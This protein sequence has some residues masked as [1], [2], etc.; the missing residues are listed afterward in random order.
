[1]LFA[2]TRFAKPDGYGVLFTNGTG[3]GKTY[4]GLGIVKR[5]HMQG[6]RNGLIV[7]PSEKIA[8]DWM[9]AGK[10]LGL[11][12]TALADTSDAGKGIV[13]TTYA[14]LGA[15]DAVM[16]RDMDFVLA[17]EAQQLMQSADAATT[18]ALDAV[19]AL[20]LHPT[21]AIERYN[22][23]N[24]EDIAKLAAM[25]EQYEAWSKLRNRDDTMDVMRD[26]LAADM[27]KLEAQMNPLRDKLAKKRAE[28]QELV[29]DRQGA[30]RPRAVFLS[31]TPF[32]Y[33][34]NVQWA[35]GYLFEYPEVK[36]TGRYNQP[37]PYQAFMVQ[38]F[39]YSMR[40][41]KLNKPS[42][43]VDSDLMQRNF[44]TFLRKSGVLSSRMLDVDFDYERRF[45][46]IKEGI[47]QKI[48]EGMKWLRE[49]D[50][51]RYWKLYDQINAQFDSLTR[52]RLLEA[53]KARE[54]VPFIKAQHDLGRKVVVF[55]DFNT[56]GGINLFNVQELLA[57]VLAAE[58]KNTDPALATIKV[59]KRG[60][61]QTMGKVEEE[62]VP[63]SQLLRE[64]IE[65]RPDLQ[66]IDFR[67]YTSPLD[68]LRTA[69]PG[70]G[71]YNGMP[72]F[73]KSRLQAIDNFNDDAQPGANLLLVQKNANAGWS[74]HDTT[75][76]HQR[77]LINLG[78]PTEPTVSIQQEGR[79]YR[80]GQASDAIFHYFNTG[81]TWERIAFA[82]TISRRAGTA[83]NLAMGE[84]A[85]GLREAYIQ[86]FEDSDP[87]YK[88]SAAD[89]KGGKAKDR[90]LVKALTDWDRARALYFAKQ[91]RNSSNK[92]QEG[93]DFFATPE[94]V[95]LK[96]VEWA[97]IRH[98]E[99]LLEP[100]A[101]DGAIARWFPEKQE[102]TVVEPSLEL[103]SRLA[104]ATDAKLVATRFEDFNTVNK[105]DVIVMNPPFGLGG[106]TSTE[107]L[108]KAIKHLNDGGRIVALLPDGPAANKRLDALL[109]GSSDVPAKPVGTFKVNG[110]DV[111]IYEGDTVSGLIAGSPAEGLVTRAE[112]NI[113]FVKRPGA[114]TANG[115]PYQAIREVKPTG[116]RTR[117]VP[118]AP[119]VYEVARIS[120]PM[121]AFE[122]AGTDVK[123]HI[124]ILDKTLDP[125]KAAA[126]GQSTRDLSDVKTVKDLF[127]RLESM[128][129]PKRQKAAPAAPP[130][131]GQAPKPAPAARAEAVER[132]QASG[133]TPAEQGA[134]TFNLVGNKIETDAPM[135]T[136]E[137]KA[138]KKLQ[139][140]FVP[141]GAMAKV[142]DK[143]TWRAQGGGGQWF[144][145]M[146]HVVRPGASGAQ[147]VNEPGA[148][149]QVD[150]FG[151]PL[152]L[153][154]QA[155][156]AATKRAGAGRPAQPASAGDMDAAGAVPGDTPM[157][158]GEFL[159]NTLVG[160]ERTHQLSARK[161]ESSRDLAQAMRHLYRSA[162]ERF[163]ALVTDKS[164]KPLAIVGGFKGAISSASVQI[165]T[166]VGEAVRVPNAA[167]IWFAHNHPSGRADL[168]NADRRLYERLQGV[169]T[170]SGIE[171]QGLIAVSRNAYSFTNAFTNDDDVMPPA[172]EPMNV[173]GIERVLDD[174]RD[175]SQSPKADSPPAALQLG[176]QLWAK[177][178]NGV[179]LLDAQMRMAGWTPL[180][181]SVDKLR[182]TGGLN[183]LY[184]ALS[185]SNA[186]SAILVHDGV[187]DQKISNTGVST[188]QNVAAALQLA[189]VNV[190]DSLNV[191]SGMSQASIGRDIADGPVFSRAAGGSTPAF[192]KWFGDSKV[193]DAAGAP[194]VMYHG[195]AQDIT[196]FRPQQANAIFVT[197]DPEF[198]A[199][200]AASSE[201]KMLTKADEWGE[202]QSSQ[203]ILPVYV[204]AENPFD[205]E[206]PAHRKAVA[207]ALLAAKG[208]VRPDGEM[209]LAR[210]DG[211]PTLYTAPVIEA[212]MAR[213]DWNFIERADVQA[214]IRSQGHDGFYVEEGGRKNLGVYEPAQLKSAVGNRGAFDGSNPDLRA[215]RGAGR[216]G[217][218]MQQLQALRDRVRKAM[219]S[220]PEI[221]LHDSPSEAEIGLRL[222]IQ[223]AGAFNDVE[224]ALYQ[225]RIY[226][227]GR[228]LASL[229]RAEFVLAEHEVAHAG[230]RAVLGDNLARAMNTVAEMNPALRKLAEQ[231]V[232]TQGL[233][234]A[235]AMEEVLV[236]IPS[237]EL[238]KLK[239]WRGLVKMMADGLDR[240]G[241][242]RA[243]AVLR[244][245]L[246]GKT[247][248][249]D[250][251]EA[252]AG[253]LIRAARD[254][255][256]AKPNAQARGQMAAQRLEAT[257]GR[258]E[259][260]DK[261]ARGRGFK[262]AAAMLATKPEVHAKLQDLWS[263][264]NPGV[265][266]RED[267]PRWYSALTREVGKVGMNAA[268][269]KGWA[270]TIKGMVQKGQVKQDE[271]EWTGLGD[272]LALQEGKV[273]KE[274]V[275]EFLDGNGVQVQEVTLS[276]VQARA[277]PPGWEIVSDEDG[278]YAVLDEDGEVMGEGE[279]R[280]EALE[281]AQDEDA[282]PDSAGAP[283]YGQYTLPG[284]E[285]YREVLLTLPT[286]DAG[287]L[288]RANEL[289]RLAGVAGTPGAERVRLLQERDRLR[290]EAGN[291][292]QFK[293][294]H[295][296]QPNILAHIRVN[297]RT[298]ADGKRVLF[299]EEIQ[300]D[301][302][303]S[304]KKQRDSEAAIEART[305]AILS[306]LGG[307]IGR[308]DAE[309]WHFR[310]MGEKV[311]ANGA[312]SYDEAKA[313]QRAKAERMARERMG[314]GTTPAA[315]FVTKTEGWLNLALKRVM[316]MAVEGG[317]DRVAFVTGEQ[318]A[319]RYDLSKQVDQLVAYEDNTLVAR[320]GGRNVIERKFKDEAELAD[321]IGKE[322][323]R[324]LL[325]ARPDMNNQRVL[326]GQDLKV[327]G[328]GMK[329]FYD[330]IVPN[331][332]KGLL[333]KVGG[334]QVGA[335]D[336]KLTGMPWSEYEKYAVDHPYRK[337]NAPRVP[338][339]DITPAMR[340]KLAAGLPLFSRAPKPRMTRADTQTQ[341]FDFDAPA[342]E[343]FAL[344]A[345]TRQDVLAQ[346]QAR[347]DET[348]REAAQRRAAEEL[349]RK[350]AERKA[351]AARMDASAENFQ[352]G[353]S[354]E[355]A[356]SGQ[357]GLFS[358][359]PTVEERADTIIGQKAA[360]KQRLDK[361]LQTLTRLSGIE[362]V[363]GQVYDTGAYL[364]NRFTPGFVKAGVIS[365]YGLADAIKDRR[366][367]LAGRQRN[368]IRD[369]GKMVQML[370]TLT[371]EESRVA[372]E[373]LNGDN[374]STAEEMLQALPE[375]SVKVLEQVRELI[376]TMSQ[377][378]MRLKQLTPD[379]FERNRFAYLHRSYAKHEL[380]QTTEEKRQRAAGV[381]IVGDQY[382]GR[383]ITKEAGMAQIK[384][385]APEWWGRRLEQGKADTSL[386]G[387]KF[388]RLEKRVR[389][390]ARGAKST[391]VDSGTQQMDGFD[392]PGSKTRIAEVVYIPM[393]QPIPAKFS[394]W[395]NAGLFEVR[396]VTG[397]KVEMWRDFTYEERQA[398]GELDE[399]RYAIVNT[400]HGMIHDIEVG[401][402]LEWLA[403]NYAE[404]SADDVPGELVPD[405]EASFAG[406]AKPLQPGQWVRVPETKI[407]GTQVLKYGT[408]AGRYVEGPVWNEIRQ[409]TEGNFTLGGP[410]WNK[411]LGLWKLSKTALSP[412]VHTNNIMANMV[413]ADW[414]NVQPGHVA[415][416]LR[417][418]LAA[419]EQDGKGVMGKAGRG[420]EKVGAI[421][422]TDAAREILNRYRDSG[423]DVGMW[424][425]NE[426]A[427]DQLTPLL[428][429]LEAEVRNSR[430]PGAGQQVGV[431]AALQ[432]AL[433]RKL[434]ES[435]EALKASKPVK[436]TGNE[437]QKL[438]DLYQ[439]E[440]D[441]FRLAA[442]LRAKEEGQTDMEAG[443]AARTSFLDYQINAPWIQA[444]RSTAW[445]F[446]SFTYRGLPM[447]LETAG[448]KPH[449]LMKLMLLA[450][451]VN[452]MGTMI[453]GGG[454]EEEERVRRMLPDEKAGKVWGIVPKLIRMPW[455]DAN[456]NPVFL[457]IRRWI[458]LGDIADVGQGNAAFGVPPSLMPG[459]PLAIFGE[460]WA[461]KSA[462]TGQPITLESDSGSE[463]ASKVFAHLYRSA[464]PNFPGLPGT[465]ATDGIANAAKGKTDVFGREGSVPQAF[466][467]ALGVKVA[468]Y[469][470]DVLEANLT[471]KVKKEADE[472]MA[473]VR[474]AARQ[475][476]RKGITA[477]EYKDIEAKQVKKLDALMDEYRAK[478]ERER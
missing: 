346:Q 336:L 211:S 436:A 253:D 279:T 328:E 400:M 237:A 422:D 393:G 174:R 230:L 236:D 106:K 308:T 322:A 283:K 93:T 158:A 110:K 199:E 445:P 105:F 375:S 238:P 149:Y 45:I 314:S 78:L 311:A 20:T 160:V 382:K 122:R 136:T 36:D 56:G 338:G 147:S 342:P 200:F 337:K 176:R 182:D 320:Q 449:K 213:G 40:T 64:F 361:A 185:Q 254:H 292:Q 50:N 61:P 154:G 141:D 373:W 386:K 103:G 41:G 440:D 190:V 63:F 397:E 2:E 224:G 218:G 415:K 168:S 44:N 394:E 37:S 446:I 347:E 302:G 468:G 273:S 317:Y 144:V 403:Q 195:T 210:S 184:R 433:Q 204:K 295:W 348:K 286:K 334:G 19:R 380:A 134:A 305:D 367:A 339:F 447:L 101:G 456:G 59:P 289:N 313:Q 258:A 163:D 49:A 225:G 151:E 191:K 420:L 79:T 162:V 100:S 39:G 46:L 455:N 240:M 262:D 116:S 125:Q 343:D 371:R 169:F 417:V 391:M 16:R 95:G 156:P 65:L 58:A 409:V 26:S 470:P 153:I 124:V 369:V 345:P 330:A 266:S 131:M 82:S 378:A 474:R 55:Y 188:G 281:D 96:M 401:K 364:L 203:N 126:M 152:D 354:A 438:I 301:W 173:P 186:S 321:M 413:M 233:R 97:D 277:L 27:A 234:M 226:L 362:F 223:Q 392:A 43:D 24:R 202:P 372:Y 198:A 282:L 459:G 426:L 245:W 231:K 123:T 5:M 387:Q 388:T 428:E 88:P 356:L 379:A 374:Q 267:R 471:M 52:R 31:A 303:Q 298:D 304:F 84:E 42:A 150:L 398:M 353:Q 271:I 113:L 274:Q 411:L 316:T 309:G 104:L 421:K 441:V 242:T 165:D 405:N 402:Y 352:L 268:P 157:P 435:F 407:P 12:I 368:Q 143:F 326:S 108:A 209:A 399:V 251:A 133:F 264:Q 429:E 462:F 183:T 117:S 351:I 73:K 18:G 300:S 453:A 3:T 228:N 128:E 247:D 214:I 359:A 85:R 166:L 341:G 15:N 217:V 418:L 457:D 256:R 357:G 280:Q 115:M 38:H 451:A 179:M 325:E 192:K 349:A 23:L 285:N 467:S 201:F 67:G 178:G 315:P 278:M 272:W 74:G 452:A 255:A 229:D 312:K 472:V 35:A 444:M 323:A 259:W 463:K 299:V 408:L 68:T 294:G 385:G 72:E 120:L 9:A 129:L 265:F 167:N 360:R 181:E 275:L 319:E 358:R 51:G 119:H 458:P 243:A 340:D 66:A 291:G 248:A 377:E 269:A 138:G 406:R 389:A 475:E 216:S 94:P 423:G 461:N 76:K 102:R 172:G 366:S 390:P 287:K 244:N 307:P 220:A 25:N 442:W 81:T 75:G 14:N 48:D 290:D 222:A 252:L 34:V 288:A 71:V 350:D 62:E 431:M 227:F 193:V 476:A 137:T 410:T 232:K 450:G 164:G 365:D 175:F 376:D 155:V 139:G 318:S 296:D 80:V 460:L 171:P 194:R 32:A 381:K 430:V 250:L 425:T 276:D 332:A 6:K 146:E 284:G 205:Y 207:D 395:D 33:E 241:L 83:E 127:D 99:A 177:G 396:D 306:E 424:A 443:D 170:G 161:V 363:A 293:S 384:N 7:V 70:A 142:A 187:L 57:Q 145:R 4:S 260:M 246:E 235:I 98:G 17:D 344:T 148:T 263:R 261:E 239:G 434:P 404:K 135:A 270:D 13:V 454:D 90:S 439:A 92:A 47:G 206:N 249:A 466:A 107:H 208:R 196:A 414:H 1:V 22:R 77:V 111:A 221:V 469:A 109:T 477:E 86:G 416:A 60:Q 437:A 53:I 130:A 8:N 215:S 10:N 28:Q 327:G 297:D 89:G 87:D 324:K 412:G 478:T 370:S 189:G 114:T 465:Y 419:S 257:A 219:P 112:G 427:Q 331:A 383:G 29:K 121:G 140:V 159:V 464:M 69:F 333:K 91:K 329:A 21:S 180:P 432:L 118:N 335:V 197:D 54:A 11:S 473:E 132:E 30:A 212:T 310:W 355:D 448:K